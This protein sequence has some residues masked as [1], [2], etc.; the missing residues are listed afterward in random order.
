MM[1]AGCEAAGLA[2]ATI[3]GAMDLVG[4]AV[5]HPT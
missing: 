1:V 2:A 5:G 4:L 3:S